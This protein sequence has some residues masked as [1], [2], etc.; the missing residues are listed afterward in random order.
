MN[1]AKDF[2]LIL[3]AYIHCIDIFFIVFMSGVQRLADDLPGKTPRVTP[4]LSCDLLSE[5]LFC[6]I[7]RKFQLCDSDHIF[8]F[9]LQQPASHPLDHAH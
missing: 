1:F 2:L 6:V 3:H 4:E 5:I 9:T 8:S 7:H